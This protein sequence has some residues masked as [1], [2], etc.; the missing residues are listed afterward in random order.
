MRAPVRDRFN[1]VQ[2]DY[3]E[4]QWLY[5]WV[6]WSGRAFGALFALLWVS[7][8]F[9]GLEPLVMPL[10]RAAFVPGLV[11]GPTLVGLG[12]KVASAC[13]VTGEFARWRLNSGAYGKAI[14]YGVLGVRRR[15]A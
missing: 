4:R 3:L 5:P 11:F 10:F 6:I 1:E 12:S 14:V 9:S 2:Q 13:G 15:S 7:T 8:S